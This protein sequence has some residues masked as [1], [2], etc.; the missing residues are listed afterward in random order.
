MDRDDLIKALEQYDTPYSEEACY[1][2][3]FKSLLT[4]FS[5]CYQRALLSGHITASA[6]I[7][8]ANGSAALLIHHKKLD[9]WLQPGGHADGDENVI[10]VSTKEAEEE[11]G[12]EL[13]RLYD[14]SIFDL[15]IHVIPGFRGLN[16]HFHYD[17]RFLFI[18][19][20][21]EYYAK[22]HESNEIA[23]FNLEAIG[24]LVSNNQSIQR[25]VLKTKSIFK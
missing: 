5:N 22:N 21:Q 16:A 14:S 25:M 12:L 6:W 3:R 20:E 11:T 8:N 15:D 4:N 19:D 2:P 18:A 1:I 7:V 13:L 23:W 10:A 17:I 24:E 9:R